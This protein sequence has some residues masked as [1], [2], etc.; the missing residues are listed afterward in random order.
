V[1][2]RCSGAL[3][4]GLQWRV[5][6]AGRGDGRPMVD[7]QS[8]IVLKPKSRRGNRGGMVGELKEVVRRFVLASFKHE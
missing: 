2:R 4:I 5:E 6:A 8:S 3:Y 1:K 7:F